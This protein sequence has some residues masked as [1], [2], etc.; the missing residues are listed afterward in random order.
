MI[1]SQPLQGSISDRVI[2]KTPKK[3]VLDSALLN[4]PHCKVRSKSKVERTRE[5]SS[6]LPYTSVW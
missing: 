1:S 6:A 5:R 4:T 2:P 3:I